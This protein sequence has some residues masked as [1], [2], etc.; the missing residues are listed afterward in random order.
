[1]AQVGTIKLGKIESLHIQV[2]IA[3]S[4]K[5]RCW[6]AGALIKAAA[7]VLGGKATVDVEVNS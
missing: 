7:W 4:F 1:M 3:S 2:K 6:I 5:V